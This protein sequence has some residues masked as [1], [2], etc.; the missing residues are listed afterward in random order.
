MPANRS[1]D[2]AGDVPITAW[3]QEFERGNHERA[4]ELWQL[5]FSRL[6]RLAQTRLKGARVVD[7]EDVAASVFE[8]LVEGARGG[9][10]D[11]VASRVELWNLLAAMTKRKCI[12]HVRRLNA[13]RRGGGEVR[14]ESVFV[15]T[16]VGPARGGIEEAA[17]DGLTPDTIA[18]IRDQFEFLLS[19][20]PNGKT[21]HVAVML[22]DGASRADIVRAIGIHE[23]SVT[24]KTTYI[25][26]HWRKLLKEVER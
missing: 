14:G 2:A 13:Q 6:A 20:L 7:G 11:D 22:L 8:S 4:T 25:I 9:R 19:K 23:D 5:Y 15:Q 12:D 3:F 24:R 18:E 17:V 10:F 1:S 26:R 21:R 16:D